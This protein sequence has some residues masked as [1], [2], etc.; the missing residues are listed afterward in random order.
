[1]TGSAAKSRVQGVFIQD[2][3]KLMKS[4]KKKTEKEEEKL[5]QI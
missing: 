1:M 3:F 2:D 4:K 5:L